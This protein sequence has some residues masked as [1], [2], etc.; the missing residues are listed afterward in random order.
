MVDE[1]ETAQYD[2]LA[3]AELGKNLFAVRV[4]TIAS[5]VLFFAVSAQYGMRLDGLRIWVPVPFIAGYT[6]T[7]WLLA[8]ALRAAH[9]S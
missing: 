8:R 9:K 5:V 6:L 3:K 7:Y 4:A 2:A 1:Q